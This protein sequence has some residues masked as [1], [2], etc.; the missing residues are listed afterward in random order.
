M[1]SCL[2][3]KVSIS[4]GIVSARKAICTRAPEYNEALRQRGDITIWFTEEA[5]AA[6]RPAKTGAH[7]RPQEIFRSQRP[8]RVLVQM[9]AVNGL[10]SSDYTN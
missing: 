5:L 7:G 2:I 3:D 1:P 9:E 4:I 10:E 8:A 6:W